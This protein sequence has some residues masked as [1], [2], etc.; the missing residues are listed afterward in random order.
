[1][2]MAYPVRSADDATANPASSSVPIR[3]T[4]A[5]SAST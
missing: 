5:V 3:P 4:T 2:K 1:M